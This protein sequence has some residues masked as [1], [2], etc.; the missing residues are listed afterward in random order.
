MTRPP[1]PDPD[2]HTP[3]LARVIGLP[4]AVSLGLGSI[5][6]T[7][8][9][10]SLA[11]AA[12]IAGAAAIIA[13]AL[14]AGVALANGLSSAQLAAAFPVSGGTYEYAWRLL[15]PTAGRLAGWLFLLAKSASAATAARGALVYGAGL[16][17][18]Q[19]PSAV[20]AAAAALLLI[21]LTA[22]VARGVQRSSRANHVLVAV[23]L[24]ALC[25]FVVVAAFNPMSPTSAALPPAGAL[26]PATAL[27][28]MQATALLFVAYTGYG[29]LA[30]LGEEVRDPAV[31]IP[32]AIAI[33]LGASMIIYVAVA[34]AAIHSV[35]AQ[36][37]AATAD[38]GT[39]PL[40]A[41]ARTFAHPAVATLVALGAVTAMV[42]VALNLLLGLSRVVL[43]MARRADLPT[44]LQ[45]LHPRTHSPARAVWAVGAFTA[46]LALAGD[47]RTTWTFSAVT[48]LLYYGITN[49]AA[50]Q[51][52]A[53]QRRFPRW[54][55]WTGL[56][57]CLW[58]ALMAASTLF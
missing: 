9:F 51:L 28:L 41:V 38:P 53:H 20:H 25:T 49:L 8:V 37:F 34:A 35:G 4:G 31:T 11:F 21:A 44:S 57:S 3:R 30:T 48:V 15:G 54:V 14:A 36:A 13:A 18:S 10:V 7:G 56:L 50:L 27:P 55:A 19:L 29:R 33:T 39:A 1:Q 5:L 46:L 43:A 26:P 52:P 17:G 42:G 22:L 32:R 58:L 47:M 45:A 40:V 2:A 12:D 16:V 23:T 6:G 24:G